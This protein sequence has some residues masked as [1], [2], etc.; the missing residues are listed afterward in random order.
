MEDKGLN[1]EPYREIVETQAKSCLRKLS[2]PITEELYDLIHEGVLIV[3]KM[4]KRKKYDGN[5]LKLK[6]AIIKSLNNRYKEIIIAS[7]KRREAINA[8]PFRKSTDIISDPSALL[9]ILD[10]LSDK[11]KHY[12]SLIL[13]PP[14]ELLE[15]MKGKT[16]VQCLNILRDYQERD[17]KTENQLRESITFR[18]TGK[19]Y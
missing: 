1:I 15:V 18:L 10:A 9:T 19:H 4:M 3:I 12:I 5:P 6:H 16:T 2:R 7:H 13:E 11:Q 14:M 17:A 8:E